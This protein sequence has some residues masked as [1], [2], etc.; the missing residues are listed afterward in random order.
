MSL[1]IFELENVLEPCW[2]PVLH[3]K[4]RIAVFPSP[5]GMSLTKLS[6]GIIKL[7]PARESFVSDIPVGNR[8]KPL[9]FLQCIIPILTFD[10]HQSCVCSVLRLSTLRIKGPEK[11]MG[12]A[13]WMT[14]HYGIRAGIFKQS[15]GA[16]NRIGIGLSYRPA[17]L[18]R[19]VEL[20]PWN[21]FLGSINV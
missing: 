4:K 3:C 2:E 13:S 10:D 17:R 11:E 7:F 19:L 15:M 1:I 6:L 8:K 16:R 21:R 9:T 20:I 5:A 14:D 12:V 18:H